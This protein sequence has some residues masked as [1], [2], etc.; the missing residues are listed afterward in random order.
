MLLQNNM[1]FGSTYKKIVSVQKDVYYGNPIR[2]LIYRNVSNSGRD[3]NGRIIVYTKS[4]SVSH[5][6]M[7]RVIDYKRLH[8]GIPAKTMRI[9][10]DPNRSAYISLI[11]HNNGICCYILHT[12]GVKVGDTIVSYG[13]DLSVF[14]IYKKGDS[15]FLK[16]TLPSTVINNIEAYPGQGGVYARS[17]GMYAQVIKFHEKLNKVSIRLRSGLILRLS[18]MCNASIGSISNRSYNMTK[19]GKAGRNRWLGHKPNVRGVAMNAVD[20]PHGGG[21]GKKPPVPK[22][23]WGKKLKWVRTAKKYRNIFND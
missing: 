9:E 17:A 11:M 23:A 5:R 19:L 6:N 20:H 22:T 12:S 3:H 13:E 10:Y 21:R 14:G 4:Y 2:M 1:K 15:V 8:F 7:Y 16:N 18:S